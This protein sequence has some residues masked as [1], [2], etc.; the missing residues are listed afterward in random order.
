MMK[1]T[2]TGKESNWLEISRKGGRS[3]KDYRSRVSGAET[4]FLIEIWKN[5]LI[6]GRI[7]RTNMNGH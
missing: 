1:Y 7:G 2:G 5:L 3:D 4:D 6:N